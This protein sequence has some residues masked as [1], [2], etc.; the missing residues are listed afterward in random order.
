M[1]TQKILRGL[2]SFLVPFVIMLAIWHSLAIAPFGDNN[3]LVSDIGTQYLEFMSLFK[4]FFD[5]GVSLYSFS[6]GIGGSIEAL[7]GYYLISPYNLICLLFQDENLPIALIWIIT[8]KIAT[9]GSTMYYYLTRHFN[10]PSFATIIFSTSYSLCGFVV[11]YSLNFMWLDALILLPLVTFGLEKL[12]RKETGSLY[13]ISLFATIMTNYYLGYMVCIYAVIYSVYLYWLAH[14]EKGAWRPKVLWQEWRKFIVVS[15]LAGIATSFI[16]LPSLVGMLRTAK[17]NFDPLSF[18]PTPRFALSAFGELGIGTYEFE[19][20]LQ[21]LPTMYSGILMVL[22]FISYF[23]CQKIS[24]RERKG[25]FFL[26]LALFLSFIVQLIN[27]VWHMFQS[28]AGFPYRNVFIFSLLMIRF[29]YAAWLK[30]DKEQLTQTLVKSAG[31]FSILLLLAPLSANIEGTANERWFIKNELV[32]NTAYLGYSLALIWLY[33]L[34]II[35]LKRKNYQWLIGVIACLTFFELGFNYQHALNAIPFGSQ[36]KFAKFYENQSELIDELNASPTLWRI[37]EKTDQNNDGFSIAYN[38][39]NDS[40]LYNFADISSYTSTLEKDVLDTLVNLGIY[41]RNVRRFTYVDEN[42]VLNL[43]LNVRYSIKP[44]ELEDRAAFKKSH[45]LHVYENSEALGMGLLLEDS[46]VK[47][48]PN[49]VIDNQE[50]ILQSLKKQEKHYFQPAKMT[51]GE[52]PNTF[53]LETTE[54]GKLFMYLPKVYWKNVDELLING[55]KHQTAIGIQTNQL[56]NLGYFKA[57]EQVTVELKGKK[58]FNFKQ[59]EIATLDEANF[60]QLLADKHQFAFDLKGQR[61]DQLRGTLNVEEDNQTVYLSIPYDD[62]WKV[63]IDNQK[64]KTKKV[65]GSFLSVTVPK[66]GEHQIRLVYRPTAPVVGG[67]VSIVVMTGVI[68]YYVVYKP[69]ARRKEAEKSTK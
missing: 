9:M 63:Y 52:K 20:R 61:D 32:S 50:S 14:P 24:K 6:N 66:K 64:V 43:L 44:Q 46:Q 30:L 69:L 7:S 55:K 51:M 18:A 13:G 11:A 48:Q 56:F 12:W 19:D 40:F 62:A 8:A 41:S 17:T 60:N 33:A 1:T 37:N 34:L 15:F 59:A 68:G 54:S 39:Y 23:F 47:L 36:S 35:I 57:G 38:S 22:L 67:I 10:Q 16:L 31:V 2:G 29:G 28:P 26:M 27:T 3:L 4:R 65:F 49:K 5:E 42:P 53:T 58:D 45:N 25:T 21:H